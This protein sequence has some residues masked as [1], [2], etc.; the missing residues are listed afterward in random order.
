VFAASAVKK[1]DKKHGDSSSSLYLPN[2]IN[3]AARFLRRRMEPG[4]SYCL[5]EFQEGSHK[6]VEDTTTNQQ[7]HDYAS[8]SFPYPYF[9]L[10]LTM[11]PRL[12]Q[13]KEAMGESKI[14]N[15]ALCRCIVI[16]VSTA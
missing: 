5:V 8:S 9:S 14:I 12:N 6:G 13:W 11:V 10:K 4:S 3:P 16:S 2:K 15:A 7:H 1:Q